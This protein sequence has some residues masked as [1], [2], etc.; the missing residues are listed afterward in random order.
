MKDVHSGE[1]F[2]MLN[3]TG[4]LE[5]RAQNN[6]RHMIDCRP[7]IVDQ[8]KMINKIY[9]NTLATKTLEAVKA[10]TI[11]PFYAPD[12]EKLP[13]Y[14]PFIKYK[15][16]VPK[17]AVD[18]SLSGNTGGFKVVKNKITGKEEAI[19]DVKKLYCLLV[20]AYLYLYR[21]GDKNS[22]LS[23]GLMRSCAQI[24]SDMFC[25]VLVSRVGLATNKERYEA[26]KYFAMKFFCLGILETPPQV[27]EDISNLANKGNM[28]NPTTRMIDNNIRERG[29]DPYAGIVS[30]CNTMF[31]ASIT[32]MRGIR[33]Q[34]SSTT[35]I[36]FEYYMREYINAYSTAAVLGLE[37]FPHFLWVIYSSAQF[38]YIFNNNTIE[39]M[40]TP[41]FPRIENE[42]IRLS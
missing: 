21:F 15:Q 2:A 8:L 42:L 33:I 39:P 25:R 36:N 17:C 5:K 28:M 14:Y 30:F 6:V 1:L 27:A 26:F 9:P 32:G 18:L 10:G 22:V 41:E 16:G 7:M 11:I 19:L 38:S 24:W 3:K 31:D 40:V 37:S 23:P 12:T 4:D 29:L 13:S 34:G 35:G 20:P